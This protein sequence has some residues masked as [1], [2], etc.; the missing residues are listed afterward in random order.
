[1]N[2]EQNLAVPQHKRGTAARS[3]VYKILSSIFTYPKDE[4]QKDFVRY[5][6]E[7]ALLNAAAQ[8]P[9]GVPA[10]GSLGGVHLT[11][12]AD[13]E[14]LQVTYSTLFDNCAGR[15]VISLH[16][17]DYS[18]NETKQIWEDLIRFYEHFGVVYNLKDCKEW[19]DH[20]GIQLEFLH[21][22]TFLEAGTPDDEIHVYVAAE[23]DF[24]ERHVAEWIPKFSEKLH[25]MAEDSP[26]GSLAQVLK[27]FVEEERTFNRQRRTVQ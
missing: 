17:K 7:L 10:M 13:A 9:F 15:P 19:P 5:G 16:E 1:M 2:G 22:L 21:Y 11:P 27:Q 14:D 12:A 18:K 4:D 6:A 25:S 20:I 23:S 26:Y 8:L 3:E 24:L